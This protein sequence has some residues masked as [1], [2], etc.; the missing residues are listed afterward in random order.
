MVAPHSHFAATQIAIV[1]PSLVGGGAERVASELANHWIERGRRVAIITIDADR[2]PCYPLDARVVRC[3]LDLRSDSR[4]VATAVWNNLRRVRRLRRQLVALK[5]DVVVSFTDVTNVTTLLAAARSG[6][7]VIVCERTDP[8]HQFVGRAWSMLRRRWYPHADAVVVQTEGVARWVASQK[9]TQEVHVIPNAAPELPAETSAALHT[10]R[11]TH[12][13]V[14]VGR[15]SREKGFDLLI[16]AFA[17]VAPR[18]PDWRLQIWGEGAERA[19][20]TERIER[21]AMGDRISLEGWTR[22]PSEV[23]SKASLFALSS[24]YE[25]FPNVLLEAMSAGLACIAFD[26]ESG[27][28][29]IIRH[30][31]DGLLIAPQDTG[32]LAEGLGRLMANDELRERLGTNARQV[33][34]RFSR[35]A[36]FGRWD[37][38]I[39]RVI[40]A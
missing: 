15:L 28:R 40:S 11:Q 23:L 29:E 10:P 33:R 35:E 20:L 22:N 26:C 19:A 32:S 3:G 13:I 36:I 21:L 18:F 4:W 12:T 7:K 30:E 14:A 1:L 17:Q 39:Q 34:E 16:S 2:E 38:L 31:V 5:P 25:G 6:L 8:R 24:R 27:P 37:A 9:W